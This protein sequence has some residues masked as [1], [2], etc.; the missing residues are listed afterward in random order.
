MT[1]LA[2]TADAPG[3]DWTSKPWAIASLTSLKPGS[4]IVGGNF[5]RLARAIKEK[6]ANTLVVNPTYFGTLS[7]MAKMIGLASQASWRL[8][9]ASCSG[10]TTD[11]FISDLA[12]SCGADYVKFGAP[13]R[14]ERVTKYNRLTEI[15]GTLSRA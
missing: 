6:S 3:I 12:C 13:A 7:E 2:K 1:K 10:D 9:F 4:E 5:E 15:F 11:T 8:I 14:G